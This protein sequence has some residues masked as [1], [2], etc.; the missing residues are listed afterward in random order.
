MHQ[1]STGLVTMGRILTLNQ[2][3]DYLKVHRSTVYRLVTRKELPAFRVGH[4]WR[5]DSDVLSSWLRGREPPMSD[6]I[7]TLNEVANYLKVHKNTIYRLATRK[8]LPAFKVGHYWRFDYDSLARW[9]QHQQG[10]RKSGVKRIP[11]N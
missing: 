11:D 5:F 1:S 8:E 10:A 2:V 6:T 4:E 7:L 3:A 9:R